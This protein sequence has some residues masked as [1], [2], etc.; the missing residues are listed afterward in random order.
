MISPSDVEAAWRLIKPYI[1]RTPAIELVAGSLGTWLG[2]RYPFGLHHGRDGLSR[3]D[4]FTCRRELGEGWPFRCD[5]EWKDKGGKNEK[6][7][8]SSHWRH[9]RLTHWPRNR[10]S[11]SWRAPKL[12][13][14]L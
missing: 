14:Q 9:S 1:R 6:S 11:K 5:P 3:V 8:P 10:A 12:C 7:R 13:Q 2:W 4:A